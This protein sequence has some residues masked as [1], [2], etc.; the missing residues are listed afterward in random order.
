MPPPSCLTN[1]DVIE[2]LIRFGEHLGVRTKGLVRNPPTECSCISFGFSSD[3]AIRDLRIHRSTNLDATELVAN[4]IV[5]SGPYAPP[6][7]DAECLTEEAV[8]FSLGGSRD[9]K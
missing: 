9:A 8:H 3:G 6:G 1:P 5:A 2:Y 4:A 7:A